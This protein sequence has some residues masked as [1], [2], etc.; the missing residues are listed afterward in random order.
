M[1]V[2]V[3]AVPESLKSLV[4]LAFMGLRRR[5]AAWFPTPRTSRRTRNPDAAA[6]PSLGN[7]PARIRASTPRLSRARGGGVLS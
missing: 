4:A 6:Q 1:A 7:R 2:G 3:R 5:L